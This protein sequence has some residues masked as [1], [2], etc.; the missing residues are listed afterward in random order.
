MVSELA[1]GPDIYQDADV[2]RDIYA[3]RAQ[4][5]PGNSGGP[6]LDT[7]GGVA[8]VVFGRAVNDDSTGYAL[9]ASQVSAGRS[10]RA[11]GDSTRL[12][13]RLRLAFAQGQPRTRSALGAC[14]ESFGP[15]EHAADVDA[16]RVAGVVGDASG[17]STQQRRRADGV[18]AHRVREADRDLR[19][20]LPQITFTCW[21]RFPER[22][23]NLVR[24]E[25]AT[26]VEIT[27]RKSNG[28][29]DAHV[30]FVGHSLAATTRP[31]RQRPTESVAR[32]R[33]ACSTQRIAVAFD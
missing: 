27:L 18:A 20:P 3:V 6:L 1:R 26:A 29:V 5:Q 33:V 7:S 17:T 23:E 31:A 28:V 11:D 19:E 25:R 22:F 15:G 9:T 12:N 8:G 2:T 21:P 10:S 30:Q 32:S 13:A 4:V 14:G 16:V 24:M